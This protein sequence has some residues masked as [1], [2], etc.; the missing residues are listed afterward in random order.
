[1]PPHHLHAGTFSGQL[2]SISLLWR[3][4]LACVSLLISEKKKKMNIS[5][6]GR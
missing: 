3:E 1:M 6:L 5:S 4:E 2:I